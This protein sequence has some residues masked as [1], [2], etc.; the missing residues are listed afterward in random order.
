MDTR[1]PHSFSRYEL[2]YLVPAE[3]LPALRADVTTRLD[4]DPLAPDGRYGVWS[5]YY[6]TPGL[7]A[8]WEKIDGERFRRKVRVRHYGT[9][10]TVG[11]GDD[12]WVEIKQRVDRTSQKRRLRLPYAAALDLCVPADLPDA[13]RP[14]AEEVAGLSRA[15]GLRPVVLVG[16]Q[17]QAYVG[18][19]HDPGVRVTFDTRVRARDRDLGF[20]D[21]P[22][23]D[24][25]AVDPTLAVMEVKVDERVPH[26]LTG[27]VAHHGLTV[28]RLSKYCK[29][30]EAFDRAPRTLFHAADD[31][32]LGGR[33]ADG[34]AADRTTEETVP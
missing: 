19:I 8:Y 2:K 1:R 20:A 6:D 5:L 34:R 25:F 28:T 14:L 23:A 15:Q 29:A 4:P 30:V 18:G 17:R 11:D 3:A 26:W 27:M 22:D 31:D 33:P 13:A 10:S 16:Y 9:P 21:P 7:R 32:G 12:V 24:R